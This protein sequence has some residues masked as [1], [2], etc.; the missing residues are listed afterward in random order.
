MAFGDGLND[1]TMIEAA[2]VGVAMSNAV[3]EVKRAAKVV[4]ASNDEDG[5]AKTVLEMLGSPV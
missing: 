3:D 1:L 2:G 5:V 4:T